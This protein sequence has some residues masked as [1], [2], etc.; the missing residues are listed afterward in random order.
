MT[1]AELAQRAFD[2]VKSIPVD[3]DEARSL[4]T[5]VETMTKKEIKRR[6]HE[7]IRSKD[8]SKAIKFLAAFTLKQKIL[9]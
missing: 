4:Q 9:R 2:W 7:L 3:G 6:F 8:Y 1:Q 5:I